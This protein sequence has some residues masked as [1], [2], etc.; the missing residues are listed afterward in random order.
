MPAKPEIRRGK[1]RRKIA[2]SSSVTPA[3]NLSQSNGPHGFESDQDK[4]YEPDWET[5][6]DADLETYVDISHQD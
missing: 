6:S 2:Q 4:L 5:A 3:T 1:N